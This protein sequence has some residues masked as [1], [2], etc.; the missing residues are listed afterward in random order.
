MRSIIGTLVDDIQDEKVHI[1]RTFEAIVVVIVF[2]EALLVVIH[3][4]YG[5]NEVA[6]GILNKDLV[7]QGSCVAILM[8]I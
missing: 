4:L 6:S 7:N 3:N 2:L 1:D 5:Q 8:N